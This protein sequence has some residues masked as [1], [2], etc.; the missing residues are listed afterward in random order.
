MKSLSSLPAAVPQ[1]ILGA[2]LGQQTRQI[3]LQ[4][5]LA[6]DNL[7]V[8]RFTAR[9]AV[10]AP[11]VLEVGCLNCRCERDEGLRLRAMRFAFA[12]GRSAR[13]QHAALPAH[14]EDVFA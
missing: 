13:L 9:E 3:T 14:T 5:A 12:D 7:V 2:L 1:A 6:S 8:E 11:F 4:T 10:S